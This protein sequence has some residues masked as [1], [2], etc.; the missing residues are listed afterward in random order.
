MA[1]L[2]VLV[3][4]L[5]VVAESQTSDRAEGSNPQIF[6]SK[7]VT[8]DLNNMNGGLAKGASVREQSLRSF[9]EFNPL[10]IADKEEKKAA[11]KLLIK[12]SN[13]HITFSAIG[14]GL[15]ALVT[16]LGA[17]MRRGSQPAIALASSGRP[18]C[19]MCS[20]SGCDMCAKM[21][22]GLSDHIMEMKSQGL[23]IDSAAVP[24]TRHLRSEP[25][26]RVGWGQPSSHNSHPLTLCYA[27]TDSATRE[28]TDKKPEE[29]GNTEESDTTLS[30]IESTHSDSPAATEEALEIKSSSTEAVDL[31]PSKKVSIRARKIALPALS[32]AA[33]AAIAPAR[34]ASRAMLTAAAHLATQTTWRQLVAPPVLYALMSINEYFTH[35]YYQH[36]EYNTSPWFQWLARTFVFGPLGRE[37]PKVRGGGH[38]EHHAE[39]LDDMTLKTDE[40]WRRTKIAKALDADP[41]RGTAFTWSVTAT[42]TVQMLFTTLPV[43]KVLGYSLKHTF[44]VLL[45]GMGIHAAVWNALHPNMHALPDITWREGVP[46]SLL[47]WARGTRFF[48]F[49]YVNHEGHHVVGGK[50]NYNV[51]C[52]GTDHLVGTFIPEKVW[53]KRVRTSY[54]SYHGEDIS[55]EQQIKNH[56]AREKF[57]LGRAEGD[58]NNVV[59]VKD[60]DAAQAADVADGKRVKVNLGTPLQLS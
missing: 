38:V 16:M 31:T 3:S 26:N 32:V 39:T 7:F 46:A 22:T 27:A 9:K 42:M 25:S 21:A 36:A 20:G 54:A 60:L 40:K 59:F 55:I 29:I 33:I 2:V 10:K 34:A 12:D 56:I 5:L 41:Y 47:A 37:T 23:D 50:G 17:R 51:A 48:R 52:P 8:P 57:G 45:P 53:R 58:K 1:L 19:P 15:L 30:K 49:L 35:K 44:M 11:Q 13:M 6:L 24:G 14:V 28:S 4:G 43:F 18:A